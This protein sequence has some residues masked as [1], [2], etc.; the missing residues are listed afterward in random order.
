MS[1]QERQEA[2][3]KLELDQ[4][5]QEG[6]QAG[7]TASVADTVVHSIEKFVNLDPEYNAGFE[8]GW[9]A[10]CRNKP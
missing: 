6:V 3:E 9:E 10:Q 2:I 7:Q 4:R 1:T 8:R 5:F